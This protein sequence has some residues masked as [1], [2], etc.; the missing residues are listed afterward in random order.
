VRSFAKHFH[1]WIVCDDA[2]DVGDKVVDPLDGLVGA[3]GC[4]TG[5]VNKIGSQKG[6]WD[7][8]ASEMKRPS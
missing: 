7:V 2:P 6:T 4:V 3:P 8:R 1:G 5:G